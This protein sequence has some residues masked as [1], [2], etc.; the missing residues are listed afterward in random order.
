M[1]DNYTNC[2]KSFVQTDINEWTFK[3]NPHY[4][5]ILEHVSDEQGNS[6]LVEI[7]NKFNM[8]YNTNTEHLIEI[9][10]KNDS[11]GKP[12]K[13][14]FTDFTSCSPTNLRYIL[15][16]FLILNYMKDCQLNNI[17][18]VE[19]GG[20]YGGLCFFIYNLASLFNITINTY[21]IFDLQSPLILQ[22][23]YLE[24]LNIN[25]VNY[26]ELD[27]I[28]NINKNSFLISNYAFSEISSNLQKKYTNDLLNTYTSHGFL[29]WNHIDTYIFV[30]NKYFTIENEVP[31][32]ADKNR[33]VYFKPNN[34]S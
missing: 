32:T 11:C 1:Y 3:S 8:I 25:N 12:K 24:N 20:G 28:K 34:Y 4:N 22:Q 10:N 5:G 26:V 31:S 23:K 19:I 33:Y 15:H 21:S 9:C 7:K 30:D 18:I 17:D 27:N 6:Y 29:V 14:K 2:I 16:S 13:Y